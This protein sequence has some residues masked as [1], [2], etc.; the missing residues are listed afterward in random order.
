MS[1]IG[2]LTVDGVT[3]T[4]HGFHALSDVNLQLREHSIHALIGPNG[5]GKSTLLNVISGHLPPTRGRVLHQGRS[6]SGRPPHEIARRGLS[7]SF[8]ITSIFGSFSV[9]DN[10]QMALMAQRGMCTRL[11]ARAAPLLREEASALLRLV[12]LDADAQRTAGELA[13]GDRK[14]LEFAI[15]MAGEPNVMLLDEPTAGMSPDEREIVINIIRSINE[16][17]GVAVL[18]TEHDI[19][20]VFA[21]ADHITVLHEGACLADGRPQDVR[22]NPRVQEVYL[23]EDQDD[24]A[25]H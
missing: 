14:R 8:Q 1:S 9:F 24:V 16:T 21:I 11:F 5:A 18:F 3:K 22:A 13:A 12:H 4:F 20:M 19:E 6:I 7:R 15:A 2:I 10:V 25:L 23:G 17:R